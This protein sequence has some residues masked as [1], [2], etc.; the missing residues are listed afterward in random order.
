MRSRM[1]VLYG[2]GARVAT[3]ATLFSGGEGVG[4]GARAA[5]LKHLWGIEY[6]DDI[7]QVARDNGFNVVTGDVTTRYPQSC[8]RPN[9]LHAS[10]PCPNFSTANQGGEETAEDIELARATARFIEILKPRIFTLENVY[11]YRKSQSWR[12]IAGTLDR[13]GYWYDLAHV[14]AADFGVPQTR[15]RMIVRALLGQ[16]VPHLPP[17]EPWVGWYSAIEDLIPTLPESQFAPWQLERLP[18][19]IKTALVTQGIP[20]DHKGGEYPLVTRCS[21]EPAFTATANH[22]QLGMRAFLVSDQSANAGKGVQVRESEEPATTI[23][24][25]ENGGTPPR[26]WLSHGRIVTMTPRA[27]ARFQS[28]PDR[29]ELPESRT[30]ACKIIGNAVPPLLYEKLIRQLIA[31]I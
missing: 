26:I 18:E 25:Q 5:G 21:E 4:C 10:T 3:I 2:Q 6:D 28:F 15:K 14:N 24:A 8:D 7:A 12:E 29:Y 20:R 11:K 9:V 17:P 1:M 23:R 22:N 30:L 27:L 16:M 31:N 13:C 19:L